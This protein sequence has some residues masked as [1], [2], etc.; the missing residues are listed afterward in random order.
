M[1]PRHFAFTM[2]PARLAWRVAHVSEHNSR[3]EADVASLT[4][5]GRYAGEVGSVTV[6]RE[7]KSGD[8]VSESELRRPARSPRRV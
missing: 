1:A 8:V 2:T 4:L 3:G 7:L 6:N 5:L